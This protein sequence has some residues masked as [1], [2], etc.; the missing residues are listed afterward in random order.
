MTGPHVSPKVIRQDHS[1]R[2]GDWS[3]TLYYA[4]AWGCQ[5]LARLRLSTPGP[6]AIPGFPLTCVRGAGTFASLTMPRGPGLRPGTPSERRLRSFLLAAN[7]ASNRC[8]I[9]ISLVVVWPHQYD[10]L[11]R[12][13]GSFCLRCA[14]HEARFTRGNHVSYGNET[15]HA[16]VHATGVHATNRGEVEPVGLLG[17]LEFRRGRRRA[18]RGFR[19][20]VRLG[21]D[22]DVGNAPARVSARSRSG[23]ILIADVVLP[24]LRDLSAFPLQ[25]AYHGG[26]SAMFGSPSCKADIFSSHPLPM[27]VDPALHDGF[28]FVYINGEKYHY[29]QDPSCCRWMVSHESYGKWY[30]WFGTEK[31]MVDFLENLPE[32]AEISPYA[33]YRYR[34][35]KLTEAERDRM[36]V[37]YDEWLRSLLKEKRRLG[38]T[39]PYRTIGRK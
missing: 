5:G 20:A 25:R 7:A 6:R 29:G 4:T 37:E 30:W 23:I 3:F 38:T 12:Q 26:R 24:T 21:L 9:G 17:R 36:Q 35:P 16:S 11:D 22:K 39:F 19:H 34:G 31:E 28:P 8:P 27:G 15:G 14:F 2:M 32:S 13:D 18:V 10:L 33:G 1:G